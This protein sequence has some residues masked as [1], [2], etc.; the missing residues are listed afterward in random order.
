M[1]GHLTIT[2]GIHLDQLCIL[3]VGCDPIWKILRKYLICIRFNKKVFPSFEDFP[4]ST[5]HTQKSFSLFNYQLDVF[6]VV[7]INVHETVLVLDCPK[8]KQQSYVIKL[9]PRILNSICLFH[10]SINWHVWIYFSHLDLWPI[11]QNFLSI[12]NFKLVPKLC[13]CQN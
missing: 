10:W 9:L 1:S 5:L 11:P 13:G 4:Q 7:A 2:H 12:N 6:D 8:T 3:R